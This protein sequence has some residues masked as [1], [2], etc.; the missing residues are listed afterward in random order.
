MPTKVKVTILL[1]HILTAFTGTV[2][3]YETAYELFFYLRG[4][5][6]SIVRFFEKLGTVVTLSSSR[7]QLMAVI[8][9]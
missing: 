8:E 9:L 4:K 3:W 7:V 5:I 6:N 1:M 2:V